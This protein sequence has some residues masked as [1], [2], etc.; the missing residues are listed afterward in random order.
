M[1]YSYIEYTGDGSTTNFSI[2]FEYL[3]QSDITVLV[4]GVADESYT[5]VNPGVIA[6]SSAP[7]QDATVRIERHSNLETRAVDFSSGS[8][9][10]EEDLDTSNQQLFNIA[11]ETH[12][13]ADDVIAAAEEVIEKVDYVDDLAA[14]AYTYER[15]A[16]QHLENTSDAEDR[17]RAYKE[18]AGTYAEAA[19]VAAS[20]TELDRDEVAINTAQVRSDRDEIAVSK[21]V[22][23]SAGE[24]ASAILVQA[25][26]K[27]NQAEAT[28]QT[29]L[30]TAAQVNA[31]AANLQQTADEL[32]ANQEAADTARTAAEAARDLAQ[33]YRDDAEA[34]R[35]LAE[36]Y[37]NAA[38][39]YDA[40]YQGYLSDTQTARDTAE[41]Y[42]NE[43]T[44][45]AGIATTKASEAATS[46]ANAATS[47]ANALSYKDTVVAKE[48]LVNPHYDAIDTVSANITSVNNAANSIASINNFGDTYFVAATAPTSPDNGDLWFDTASSTMKVYNGSSW[49]N[50]GSSVNGTSNRDEFTATSGQTT[51]NTTYDPGYVDVYL[52]GVKLIDG[53]DFTATDGSN[54]VLTA[55]ASTGD[56][57][58]IVA[59]GTFILADHYS[60]TQVDAFIDDVET[61]A[62]AG[63]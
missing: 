37:K 53:V 46:A 29:A 44:T 14:K 34:A 36:T 24:L 28:S 56:S 41:S 40:T 32:Q 45:Q 48:A 39:T 12:D 49:Q 42:K 6:T 55:G 22:I 9:L 63:L 11:Q 31:T 16:F 5:F 58:S 21:S 38:G 2:P 4:D 27:A 15:L 54:V 13:R 8:V 51:F 25:T 52:N 35:D 43:A 3:E 62:L 19:E 20:S 10:T 61:L 17:A 30:D 23:E 33:D 57:V 1:A 59:Y 18:L 50:A 47:E 60:K 26:N 7:S